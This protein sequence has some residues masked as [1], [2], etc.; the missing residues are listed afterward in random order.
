MEIMTEMNED[1]KK[2]NQLL[3]DANNRYYAENDF[4]V[5]KDASKNKM[6][7][8]CKDKKFIDQLIN[9]YPMSNDT[10]MC[11]SE[12]M[13]LFICDKNQTDSIKNYLFIKY[14]SGLKIG[15]V[16]EP[17]INGHNMCE[18]FKSRCIE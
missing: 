16:I 9:I 3:N 17:I 4:L 12:Y 10:N 13:T 8:I 1:C 18:F 5:I 6:Q 2:L 14:G 15:E 7:E 11:N